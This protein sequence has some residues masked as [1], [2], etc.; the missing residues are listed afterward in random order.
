[1]MVTIV[2]LYPIVYMGKC[3]F[4]DTCSNSNLNSYLYLNSNDTCMYNTYEM[5]KHPNDL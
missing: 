2:L 5:F 4:N 1:M 3:V